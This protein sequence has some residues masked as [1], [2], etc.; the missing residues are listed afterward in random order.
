MQ[1]SFDAAAPRGQQ[2]TIKLDNGTT[3]GGVSQQTALSALQGAGQSIRAAQITVAAA[4]LATAQ[5]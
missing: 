2:F 5:V 4:K 1:I 3:L